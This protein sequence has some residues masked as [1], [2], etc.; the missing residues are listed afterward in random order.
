MSKQENHIKKIIAI[1]LT[2]LSSQAFASGL[3]KPVWVGPKAIGMGGAFVGVADDTTAMFHNPAGISQLKHKHNFQIGADTLITDLDYTPPTGP[4]ESAD[5]EYL[6]VPSFGY[7]NR[8]FE[9][10][11]FGLGVFFPHGNGGKFET[12][13]TMPTNPNEGRIYTMEIAPTIAFQVLPELSLGASLRAT[14]ISTSLKGQFFPI[15][16]VGVDNL[17]TLDVSGWG[18]GAS[19]GALYQ[20]ADW[21]KLGANYRSNIAKTLGGDG[22]FTGAGDFD[23]KLKMALPTLITAGFSA[24]TSQKMLFSFQYGFERNSEIKDFKLSSTTLGI[25]DL[26]LVQNWQDSHTFHF[27]AKYDLC[28]QASLIAGYARDFNKSIPDE[29]MNRITGDID[30]HEASAGVLLDFGRY[31]GGLAWNGRWGQRD[32]PVTATNTA[33]GHYEAF[34]NTISAN[35]GFNL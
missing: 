25:T 12:A 3:S 20:P 24:Q 7:V 32:I 31:N 18:Y 11:S 16:G 27:G 6:P 9:M 19:I 21:L 1:Y 33:P 13:S 14:R 28:K 4:T 34:V 30:A 15:P 17:E 2:L 22:T 10:I 5:Q 23:A 29:T 26:A 8:Q 35:V